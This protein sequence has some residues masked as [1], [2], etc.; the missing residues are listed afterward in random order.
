M[1]ITLTVISGKGYYL[2]KCYTADQTVADYFR[3]KMGQNWHCIASCACRH[4]YI[5]YCSHAYKQKDSS[6][7]GYKRCF[8]L[9]RTLI[10]TAHG[11]TLT[12]HQGSIHNLQLNVTGTIWIPNTL[13]DDTAKPYISTIQKRALQMESLVALHP[14]IPQISPLHIVRFFKQI[15]F[16]KSHHDIRIHLGLISVKGWSTR[17]VEV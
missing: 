14:G 4:I 9:F 11:F 15:F 10:S 3:K 8:Y 12:T 13:L 7:K 5:L 2:V 6:K 1:H 16:S 17:L